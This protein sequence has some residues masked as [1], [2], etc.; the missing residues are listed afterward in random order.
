MQWKLIDMKK[1]VVKLEV[2]RSRVR[3][4]NFQQF[5]SMGT[6]AAMARLKL[7]FCNFLLI[8]LL[9]SSYFHD[10]L[11]FKELVVSCF[12]LCCLF[13]LKTLQKEN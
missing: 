8:T 7:F 11:Y 9:L 12:I 5:A 10:R 3:P 1:E 2:N 13:L 4:Y 6:K